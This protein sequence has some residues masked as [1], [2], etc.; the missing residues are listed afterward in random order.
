MFA[1]AWEIY[2]SL[3]G[4]EYLLFSNIWKASVSLTLFKTLSIP[5]TKV[6]ITFLFDVVASLQFHVLIFKN[7]KISVYNKNIAM[8]SVSPKLQV[9]FLLNKEI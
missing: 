5:R 2:P 9:V 3:D 4:Y 7:Y 6:N 8:G 1:I